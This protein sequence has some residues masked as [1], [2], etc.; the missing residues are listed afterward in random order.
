MNINFCCYRSSHVGGQHDVTWKHSIAQH[1]VFTS[2]TNNH[3]CTFGMLLPHFADTDRHLSIEVTAW[4]SRGR[5]T[6]CLCSS[7]GPHELNRAQSGTAGSLI[8]CIV[9]TDWSNCSQTPIAQWYLLHIQITIALLVHVGC[10]LVTTHC[11][12]RSSS[13]HWSHCLAVK[14]KNYPLPV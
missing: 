1:L 2:H 7:K 6:P 3:N 14:G 9:L 10:K 11:R 5:S 12:H 13:Q 4:L 8:H